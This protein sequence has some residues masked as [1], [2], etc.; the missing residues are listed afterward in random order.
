[1]PDRDLDPYLRRLDRTKRKRDSKQVDFAS[2]VLELYPSFPGNPKDLAKIATQ[3]HRVGSFASVKIDDAIH[4]AVTAL[5]RH[6]HTPYDELLSSGC[7]KKYARETVFG[8]IMRTL[9]EWRQP[10]AT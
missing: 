4:M 7:S 2:R 1:M 5:A 9:Y 8:Q 10:K 3:K 6:D